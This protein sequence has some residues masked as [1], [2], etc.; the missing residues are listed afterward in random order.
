MN[1]EELK[2]ALKRKQAEWR[3]AI[4]KIERWET[5]QAIGSGK[6][7]DEGEVEEARN[8]LESAIMPSKGAKSSYDAGKRETDHKWQEAV[9]EVE[10]DRS[11]V[12]EIERKAHGN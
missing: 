10:K 11:I 7:P 8:L 6:V 3:K 5:Y 9:E 1:S 12:C 2:E 4:K